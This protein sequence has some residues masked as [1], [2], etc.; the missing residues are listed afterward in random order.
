MAVTISDAYMHL[1]YRDD[2][3]SREGGE[4]RNKG[5]VKISKHQKNVST[6]WLGI[7]ILIISESKL[8]LY[9]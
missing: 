6:Q 2:R 5:K 3:G 4:N 7:R 1:R 9:S 8:S